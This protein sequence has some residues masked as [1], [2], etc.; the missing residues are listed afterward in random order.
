MGG[1]ID[2]PR[3]LE[4]LKSLAKILSLPENTVLCP[5]HGPLTTV[6]SEKK[7]NAFYTATDA[8]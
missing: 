7:G 1:T 3:Y 5:E 8:K 6:A 2:R 4:A